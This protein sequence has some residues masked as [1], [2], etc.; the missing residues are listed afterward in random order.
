MAIG[1]IL[2]IAGPII[3]GLFGS[4]TSSNAADA[5][6]QASQNANATTMAMFNQTQANL[7]PWRE[8]GGNALAKLQELM[9]L[10]SPT[11]AASG[12]AWGPPPGIPGHSVG[13]TSA[14]ASGNQYVWDGSAWNRG[15][16]AGGAAA[17]PA[18]FGSLLKGFSMSDYQQ[19]PYTAWL[20]Q[21]GIDAIQNSAAARGMTGN[22]LRALSDYGQ[23]QSISDYW[24]QF[25]AWNQNQNNEFSRL[26][27]LSGT[28]AN[29]AGLTA[30]LGMNTANS[31]GNNITGAGNAQAAGIVGSANALSGGINNAM[32]NYMLYNM[33][34]S[35]GG[36]AYSPVGIYDP[37]YYGSTY[38]GTYGPV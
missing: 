7:Q 13:Q 29:A 21:Q 34:N 24:N 1:S 10:S 28:G 6:V 25:N 26:N 14:D 36:G 2:S 15:T 20:K 4:S 30:N 16:P 19:S 35:A 5:Q 31:I 33:M 22:T 17:T 8:G 32:Q 18:D 27:T 11:P 3:G 38:G 9:G 37:G 23:Q 12:G